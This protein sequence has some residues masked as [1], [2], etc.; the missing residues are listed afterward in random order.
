MVFLVPLFVPGRRSLVCSQRLE[1]RWPDWWQIVGVGPIELPGSTVRKP[2][3][4]APRVSREWSPPGHLRPISSSN[5]ARARLVPGH[6]AGCVE[7]T[8]EWL[9]PSVIVGKDHRF[10]VDN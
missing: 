1:C 3:S 5:E 8:A 7:P 9:A 4:A 10:S 2:N 6:D